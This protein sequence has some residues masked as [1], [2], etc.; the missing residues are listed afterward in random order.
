MLD[1]ALHFGDSGWDIALHNGRV[2]VV[3]NTNSEDF[4]T[5]SNAYDRT[6]AGTF[7]KLGDAFLTVLNPAGGGASDL[8]YSTFLGNNTST[9]AF[10]VAVDSA[11][12]AHLTGLT[13][14]SM[15]KNDI[16]DDFPTTPGAYDT[17]RD[18]TVAENEDS[19]FFAK[20]NPAGGGASDL[21]YSTYLDGSS[22]DVG[23]G[24]TLDADGT[25]HIIG[26]TG[27]PNFP[28][29]PGA[30]D[31]TCG[32]DGSCDSTD[33]FIM[34]LRPN[35]QGS[36]DLHYSTFLGGS[37]HEGSLYAP[38]RDFGAIALS[39]NGD[40]LVTGLTGSSDFPVTADAQS[41][42]RNGLED[43]YLSRLRLQGQGA[44]DLVYSTYLG[45]SLGEEGHGIAAPDNQTVCLAGNTSS[46]NFPVTPGAYDTSLGGY[47]DAFVTC[48][49]AP[50]RPD[51]TS[52]TKIVAPEE[53]VVG[54]V[55]TFK[56]YG[57]YPSGIPKFPSFLRVRKDQDL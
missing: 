48:L 22:G 16:Y 26:G 17:A 27:S 46:A 45:G 39:P 10:A 6:Y 19:A 37:S 14:Y 30:Y 13:S 57:F 18:H 55:V 44:D 5:T 8:F 50:P 3:G 56:Y 31:T 34:Q 33:T 2:Y 21:L 51:L 4:P 42:F 49:A 41:G 23:Y 28:T 15:Y 43:A 25:A 38:N 36:A 40:V 12:V 53:A 29:T 20:I 1:G 9:T 35:G 47:G 11:G 54:E 32:P 52:S 24:I 7:S